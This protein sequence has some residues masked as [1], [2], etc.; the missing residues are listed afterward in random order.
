MAS[1]LITYTANVSSWVASLQSHLAREPY[2]QRI[3]NRSYLACRLFGGSKGVP[4]SYASD[5]RKLI[6]VNPHTN[7]VVREDEGA[8]ADAYSR[9]YSR[10]FAY[11]RSRNRSYALVSRPGLARAP[12]RLHLHCTWKWQQRFQG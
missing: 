10:L 6:R 5:P 8:L 4:T 7:R 12:P 1:W 11:L 3:A 9:Y 2:T